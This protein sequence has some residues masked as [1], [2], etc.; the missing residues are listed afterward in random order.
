MP[1]ILITGAAGVAGQAVVRR[2]LETRSDLS[3][4]LCDV[5]PMPSDL[6]SAAPFVRVDTRTPG[7]VESAV[8]GVDA[9]VHLAAWHCAHQPAVSDETIFAVNVDGTFNVV[10]ACRR[11][12]V[13]ALVFASSMAYGHGG[14]YGVTKVLGEDLCRMFHVCERKPAVCLRYHDFVPK[15]YL[16]FGRMLLRNGVDARDVAD[17]TIASVD[18]VLAGKV[19]FFTTV[20]HHQLGAPRDVV[21][22]FGK[23]GADWLEAQLPGAIRLL[24]KYGIDLPQRLEQH[25]LSQA[26]ELM[27]WSPRYNALDFLRDLAKRD[28]AGED[29]GNLWAAG[30]LPD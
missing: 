4:K 29:V 14:V 11:H 2:V 28:G 26:K 13:K 3:L 21:E 12:K 18:A 20:V 1:T 17:A 30:Q 22:N 7:D 9:V 6:R 23:L 25:D 24:E 27:N 5:S 16:A 19:G 15:S 8:A 10:Q